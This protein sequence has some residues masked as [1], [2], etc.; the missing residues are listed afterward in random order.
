MYRF[1]ARL[2]GWSDSLASAWSRRRPRKDRRPPQLEVLE[3]RTAP[4]VYGGGFRVVLD[5]GHGGADPGTRGAV[6]GTPEKTLN[7]DIATRVRN[8]LTAWG[9]S[10]AM[11]RTGDTNPTLQARANLAASFRADSFLSIHHNGATTSTARGTETYVRWPN[12]N[13]NIVPDINFA[14]YVQYFALGAITGRVNR[15]VKS[16]QFAVLYD[17]YLGNSASSAPTVSALLEVEFL[18]NPT[19]DTYLSNATN[20]EIIAYFVAAGVHFQRIAR[21]GGGRAAPSMSA[22]DRAAEAAIA[23]AAAPGGREAVARASDPFADSLLAAT[24]RSLPAGIDQAAPTDSGGMA[25]TDD[26]GQPTLGPRVYNDLVFDELAPEHD[27]VAL[28]LSGAE[29][30]LAGVIGG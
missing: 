28:F 10:V 3:D 1:V 11:T 8:Y 15:G 2:R 17:P 12:D 23:L 30:D 27:S 16:A 21:C 13:V 25:A 4:C 20:R 22:G 26:A 6:T 29:E 5:P 24:E 19:V 14:L 9:Y 18:T 7:L